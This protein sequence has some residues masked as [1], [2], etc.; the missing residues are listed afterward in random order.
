[1]KN[2]QVP[3]AYTDPLMDVDPKNKVWFQKNYL[4]NL[5]KKLSIWTELMPQLKANSSY[6]LSHNKNFAYFIRKIKG[7]PLD[8]S[9][10]QIE[11]AISDNF[12]TEDLQMEEAVNIVK[13]MIFL[14]EKISVA[15]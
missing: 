11:S 14:K 1:M 13:D 12:G 5:Q 10:D 6:R 9:A 2:D 15:E 8:E 4:P 7:E 3:P